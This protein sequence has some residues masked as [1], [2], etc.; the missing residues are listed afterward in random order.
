[1]SLCTEW[2]LVKH[3]PE[4]RRA[5]PLYCRSWGCECCRPRRK[6][7]L[8]ALC[9]AG[10]PTRFITLTVNPKH[11][12]DPH[13]RL[14]ALPHA[15]RTVLKRLR[16]RYPGAPMSYLAIVEETRQGEPHLHILFRGPYIPQADLSAM[17]GE[18]IDSPVVDIRRIKGMREVIRY[19]AKYVTKAPAQFGNGKR[20][21]RG[22][23]WDTRADSELDAVHTE[24]G[25]WQVS[26]HPLAR[27]WAVWS[28]FGY[29]LDLD[30]ADGIIGTPQKSISWSDNDHEFTELLRPRPTPRKR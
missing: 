1:M 29:K 14:L 19:V 20:Y 11:G 18:L 3:L 16:R 7:Q 22:Q 23:N 5:K 12:S 25:Y 8:M 2:S 17:M 15:W 21:W 27:I 4:M 24:G 30:G 9:A 6:R 26:H 13:E 28:Y 10:S